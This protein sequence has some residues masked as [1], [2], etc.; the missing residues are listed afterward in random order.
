LKSRQ[1]LVAAVHYL[2]KVT[3]REW[4]N[5]VGD[6]EIVILLIEHDPAVTGRRPLTSGTIF[7][8][9]SLLP[10]TSRHGGVMRVV[11]RGPARLPYLQSGTP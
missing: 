6:G 5:Q 8:S 1:N 4:L 2:R 11:G 10:T 9:V 3:H 7:I